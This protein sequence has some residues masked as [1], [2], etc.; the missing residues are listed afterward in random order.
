MDIIDGASRDLEGA[1]FDMGLGFG[2]SER[3]GDS[4]F[5]AFGSLALLFVVDRHGGLK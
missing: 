5:L 1:D 4:F 2:R 3:D